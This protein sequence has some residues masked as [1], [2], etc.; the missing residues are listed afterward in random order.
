MN[1]QDTYPTPSDDARDVRRAFL[2]FGSLLAPLWLL[3]ATQ[4]SAPAGPEASFKFTLDGHVYR[5]G[6]DDVSSALTALVAIY[7]A[8]FILLAL[9]ATLAAK[10]ARRGA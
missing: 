7:T 9:A 6:F 8:M 2:I 1:N 4:Y 5:A 3:V 10:L